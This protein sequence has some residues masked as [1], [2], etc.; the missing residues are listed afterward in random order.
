MT[1]PLY[2]R[3]LDLF[4]AR[5]AALAMRVIPDGAD[6]PLL[7][8]EPTVEID[9]EDDGAERLWDRLMPEY[10]GLLDADVVNRQRYD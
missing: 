4:R 10:K 8:P 3:W 5:K 6:K 2:A 9:P 7:P 1:P